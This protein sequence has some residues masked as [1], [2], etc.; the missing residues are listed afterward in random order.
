MK[1][2]VS[3]RKI[4]IFGGEDESEGVLSMPGVGFAGFACEETLG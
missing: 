2:T 4:P 1:A 3:G